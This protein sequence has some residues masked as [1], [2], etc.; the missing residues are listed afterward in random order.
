MS[1]ELKIFVR[2][3]ITRQNSFKPEL[4]TVWIVSESRDNVIRWENRSEAEISP[5][6]LNK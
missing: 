5:A 6:L 3:Q 4:D 2:L 1:S